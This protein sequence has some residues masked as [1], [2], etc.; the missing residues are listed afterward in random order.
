MIKP[1]VAALKNLF[2][3]PVTLKHTKQTVA[4]YRGTIKYDAEHCIFC[5][6][7]EKACPPN[8]IV[9]KCHLDGSKTYAYNDWLCIYCG[10]CVRACPKAGDALWQSQELQPI[11]THSD[12]VNSSWFEWQAQSAKS[13]IALKEH[14]DRK[15]AL[16]KAKKA[17]EQEKQNQEKGE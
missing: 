2:S 13:R 4:N 5:D 14:K 10:E 3:Q 12:A 9:F 8:A 7:C 16:Q 11:A 1:F 6:Q 15:K 17:K